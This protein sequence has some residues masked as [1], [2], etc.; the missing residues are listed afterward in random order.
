MQL[1]FTEKSA[2]ESPTPKPLPKLTRDDPNGSKSCQVQ[3]LAGTVSR[4]KTSEAPTSEHGRDGME[5]S[6]P[7][8]NILQLPA[9]SWRAGCKLAV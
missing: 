7:S 4:A 3:A 1:A 6:S 5:K 8:H 2:G 9:V